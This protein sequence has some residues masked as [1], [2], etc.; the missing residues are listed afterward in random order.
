[1]AELGKHAAQI[2]LIADDLD[3]RTEILECSQHPAGMSALNVIPIINENDTVAVEELQTTFGD[4]DRLA[5]MVAASS[6]PL[7]IILSDVQ[8][9]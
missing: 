8:G 7:L 3:D 4:N 9:L 2:L 5:A 1:M 6:K